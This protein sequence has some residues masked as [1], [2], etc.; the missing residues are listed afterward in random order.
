M[1]TSF[2]KNPKFDKIVISTGNI[3]NNVNQLG[4]NTSRFEK[5]KNK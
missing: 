2:A 1:D 4:N 3:L 5:K